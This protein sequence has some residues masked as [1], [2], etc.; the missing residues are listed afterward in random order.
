[1]DTIHLHI[2]GMDCGGCAKAVENALQAVP[3]VVS[4][5]A[6]LAGKAARVEA[7]ATV[8]SGDLVAA[9]EKAGYEARVQG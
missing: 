5:R 6:D 9:V 1:M 2:D 7:A 3:G 8:N 4:A